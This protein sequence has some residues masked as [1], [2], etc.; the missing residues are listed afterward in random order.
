MY[1]TKRDADGNIKHK[2]RYVVKGYSQ[3]ENV[4]YSETFAPTA[5]MT[6]D[7]AHAISCLFIKW[8]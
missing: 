7:C 1:A 6:S 8:M 4:D 3:K 5:H 2:A